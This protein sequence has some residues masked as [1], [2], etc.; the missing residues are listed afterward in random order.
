MGRGLNVANFKKVIDRLRQKSMTWSEI[1]EETKLPKRTV[2]RVLD[3]L[4]FWSLAKK[5]ERSEY[6]VWSEYFKP[7]ETEHDYNLAIYHSKNLIDALLG[8][9]MVDIF[10]EKTA[11]PKVEEFKI[12]R[13][14]A[15]EHLRT[16]Y[17]NIFAELEKYKILMEKREAV[18]EEIGRIDPALEFGDLLRDV[19]YYLNTKFAVQEKYRKNAE[20]LIRKLSPDRIEF[21]KQVER[22]RTKLFLRIAGLLQGVKLQVENG[23]PLHGACRLCPRAKINQ[24]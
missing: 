6:W 15:E 1:A 13:L 24:K 9:V 21:I 22:E 12:L 20:R 16:G 2:S 3:S 7:F 10:K 14:M 5:D 23:E 4:A 19:S 18:A 11:D 8:V 17:P